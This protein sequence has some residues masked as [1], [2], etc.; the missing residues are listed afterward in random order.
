MNTMNVRL[1]LIDS[2]L[3]T[4]PANEKTYRD[5]VGSKAPDAATMEDEVASLG[6][7]A[8]ADK[9]MT[10]FM[11]YDDGRPMMFAYQI[12]GF[13]KSACKA[14]RSDPDTVS[15]KLKAYKGVIDDNMF[16]YGTEDSKRTGNRIPINF[17]GDMAVCERPLRAE[18]M[19]GPRVTLASSEEV[20]EGST[21]LIKIKTMN[22]GKADL[23][24][25]VREWLNYG[26]LH[27]LGQW[28]NSGRGRF[29][30][31]ELDDSGKVIGGNA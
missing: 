27:G 23:Q 9:G 16:V 24:A 7:D 30:W 13:F 28:R 26:E 14:L 10:V 25:L 11:R 6:V 22:I 21:M 3:G 12:K 19:Q 5:W 8:V 4:S 18:T 17:G 2:M 31:E 20:P 29:V 15:S 1:T